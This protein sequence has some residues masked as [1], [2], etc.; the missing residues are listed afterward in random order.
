[1]TELERLMNDFNDSE[2]VTETSIPGV[3]RFRAEVGLSRTPALYEPALAILA[4]GRKTIF[5]GGREMEYNPENYLV[6]SLTIP[7]ECAFDASSEEPVIGIYI[8][9]DMTMLHDLIGRMD[10]SDR[11]DGRKAPAITVSPM[12]PPMKDAVLRL[13]GCMA[14]EQDARALGTGLV[15]EVLYRVLCGEQAHMLHELANHS[16]D[17]SRIAHSLTLLQNSIGEKIDVERLASSA[18]MSVSAFHRA[19]RDMIGESPIQYLK[20]LRL[21]K[22]RDL[23]LQ[24]GMKAYMAADKVGYES[25][26]QFSREFKRYFGQSPADMVRQTRRA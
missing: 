22:A 7:V 20:K 3:S 8:K 17:F 13:V 2:G 10:P 6:S 11:R 18:H 5:S 14:N 16:A 12:D 9:L 4:R 23:M 26:S 24:D 21:N 19:F 25:P 15:R 1:M